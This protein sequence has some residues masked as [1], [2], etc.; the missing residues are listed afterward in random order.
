MRAIIARASGIVAA[1]LV[2]LLASTTVWASNSYVS[3]ITYTTN[4]FHPAPGEPFTITATFFGA[5][6]GQPCHVS[7]IKASVQSQV[8]SGAPS[9]GTTHP[10][11][12]LTTSFRFSGVSSGSLAPSFSFDTLTANGK[13]TCNGGSVSVSPGG[14]TAPPSVQP[15]P[16]PALGI[17]KTLTSGSSSVVPGE[18]ATYRI[19][20]SN[21]GNGDASGLTITDTLSSHLLFVSAPVSAPDTVVTPAVGNSGVVTW[22][23]GSLAAGRTKDF[24]LSVKI[25]DDGF[26]GSVSNQANVKTATE[27]KNSNT[28]TLDVK[29]VPDIRLHKTINGNLET[30]VRLPAG[31]IVEYQIRYENVG[32]G[33]A[34][35]VV[36]TDRIPDELIGTPVL[37]GGTA[38]GWSAG[39]R[40]ATWTIDSVPAGAS[41]VVRISAQINPALTVTDFDN[42]ASVI[43]TGG[44]STDSNLVNVQVDPEPNFEIQ[45]RVDQLH[46]KPGEQVNV[47]IALRNSGSVKAQAVSVVDYL[48][49]G[50]TPVTGTY[51]TGVYD[52]AAVPRK[53]LTWSLGDI[54]PGMPA[55]LSYTVT[56]D[57]DAPPGDATNIAIVSATNL[58]IPLQA[59]AKT[60]FAVDGVVDLVAHKELL[61]PDQDHVADGDDV[62]YK[63]W[64]ENKGNRATEGGITLTDNL[65]PG[66]VY[67][68]TGQNWNQDSATQLSQVIS[69]I[70]AGGRS[71]DYLLTLGVDGS[72]V[73]DGAILDNQVAVKNTT[74]GVEYRHI[75]DP[76]RVYYNLPPKITLTKTAKPLPTQPVFPGDVIDYTLT[77]KLE[78]LAGVDDLVVGDVLPPGLTFEG[79]V[80]AGYSI[81]TATDGRQIVSWP[82]TALHAGERQYHLRARVDA[83]LP[84]GT[85][86]ENK[87]A[88]SYNNTLALA[89]V[90][91]HVTEAAI[92]LEKTR[93]DLQAQ[94]IPG[95]VLRYDLT[96][97]NTGKIPLTDIVLT[98]NLPLD[99][100]LEFVKPAP[101]TVENGGRTLIWNLPPLD[102]GR[103]NTIQVNINT[104]NV[105]VGDQLT[106]TA[107]IKSKET[108]QQSAS[109]VSDVREAPRLVITKSADRSTAYPGDTVTFTLHYANKGKGSAEDV[110]LI[111]QLPSELTFLS[112]TDQVAPDSNGLINWN[113]GVLKP[114]ASGTKLIKMTVPAAGQYV[115]A[116]GIDN[117]VALVSQKDADVDFATV[118]LTE[119]PS[120]TI[121]KR[122]GMLAPQAIGTASPGDALHYV[123]DL[124]KTGGAATDVLVADLLP[125]HTTYV[126]NSA[127][128]PLDLTLSNIDAGLLVWNVGSLPEGDSAGQLDF[129]AV[130]DSV[131]DNGTQLV[132]RA[133]LSST[134][135]GSQ[136]SNEVVTQIFSQPVFGLVKK[137][138]KSS[139]FSPATVSGGTGDTVVYYL[140]VTNSGNTDATNV[141]ISD[142]LPKE[143]VIDP[144]STTG[145]V[146]D[147]SVTWT[148]PTLK[149]G[150]PITLSVAATVQVGV[151]EGRTLA[152]KASLTTTM[153]GVGG[154]SSNEVVVTVSGE[155]IMSMTKSASTKSVVP[156]ERFSYT[157]TYTNSGTKISDALRIEDD[158]PSYVSFVSASR[159]GAPDSQQP[160]TVVWNNLAP[161]APGAS[162]SVE[163]LV[164]V[165]DI[166]PN[167]TPLAN[168]ALLAPVTDPGNSTPSITKGKPPTVSSGPLLEMA[169]VSLTGDTVVAGDLVVFDLA[170]VNLGGDEAT[171]L[172][173]TDTLPPGM[174]FVDASGNY[175]LQR[176]TITWTAPTLPAKQ[177]ANVTLTV[178][179]DTDLDNGY[180]LINR[181]SLTANELPLPLIDTAEVVVRN[182]VLSISKSADA[183]VVNSGVS[184]T[185]QPGDTLIYQLDYANLGDSD[186]SDVSIVETLPPEVT[187]INAVPEPDAIDGQKLTWNVASLPL[188]ATTP[189]IVQTQVVD[190]LREGTIIHNTA[191]ISSPATG[192]QLSNEVDTLVFSQ[193][194][195]AIEKSSAQVSVEAGETIAYDISVRNDGSDSIANIEVVDTLPANA[196]FLNA[197]ANG[198]HSGEAVGG[199]VTWSLPNPLLPGEVAVLHLKATV[200][201]DQ[202]DGDTVFN[203]VSAF[204]ETPSGAALPTVTDTLTTPVIGQPSLELVYSVNR[205]VVV[206]DLG[207]RYT[208]RFR[209]SGNADALNPVLSAT[210]PPNTRPES[211]DAGGR[212]ENGKAVWSTSS[213]PPTGVIELEFTVLVQQ[214]A[215][216]GDLLVSKAT[217]SADNAAPRGDQARTRVIGQPDLEV[218]K[219]GPRFFTPGDT[220]D[221]T[222]TTSNIGTAPAPGV[223]LV[224]Q[225][226]AGTTF[227]SSTPAP[228]SQAG[229]S[230]SWDLGNVLNGTLIPV[231]L[232]VATDSNLSTPRL[233][234]LA[235]VSDLQRDSDVSQWESR[236]TPITTLDIVITPDKLIERP[237]EEVTFTVHWQNTGNQD[238]SGTVV[239][240]TLPS[241]TTLTSE[242]GGT[243]VNGAIE[244]LVGDL[245]AGEQGEKTFVA[246]VSPTA[247][248]GTHV[249]SVAS[250][251][252]NTGAPASSSA[253]VDVVVDPVVW[254]A[255]SAS[256]ATAELGDTVTF[257]IDYQNTG[258]AP[259]TEV[260]LVD[261]LPLGLE[262]V[263]ASDGGVISADGATVTWAL[264]DVPASTSR[265]VTVEVMVTAIT[266]DEVTNTATLA[267]RELPDQS[268]TATL[269]LVQSATPVPIGRDWLLLLLAL[270][271]ALM[272]SATFRRAGQA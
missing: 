75:S 181:A 195:L 206:P 129:Y 211:I 36:I 149:V 236:F 158:L 140:M 178:K 182:A 227:V 80:D 128:I 262:A 58:P 48:P 63:I 229:Q 239:R 156:G 40:E 64:V 141:T 70:A 130:I 167:K 171:G 110:R 20:V 86:L 99:T 148:I 246:R 223:T 196:A 202:F 270:L 127:N 88:A 170:V 142:H 164:Q 234:N 43:W 209:N 145:T 255:K 187:F 54:D 103:S 42:Q 132:N 153:P 108:L 23:V 78:T 44:A 219:V 94:I 85:P 210:L 62:T 247:T 237:S 137:A 264:A 146:V 38:R 226:P 49:D 136:L 154:I 69:D 5:G 14:G 213:L 124:T 79:S 101:T 261:N 225:L 190:D 92:T 18:V 220:I 150:V 257:S 157:L 249:V 74:G 244:W 230:L 240:A 21:K 84:L 201:A 120:F 199:S 119:L 113:L 147:Q 260:V 93:S 263:S 256:T 194:V 254:L 8:V 205:A 144:T 10:N 180:S 77:A 185:G 192:T 212:F 87:G 53:T 242:G 11:R 52:P 133:G 6:N 165:N 155:P 174:T 248:A 163:V 105:Q 30:G 231:T 265:S 104:D 143:L 271:T 207:I 24:N 50:V 97:T 204:G 29:R 15:T 45:K 189:I 179:T 2:L 183:S 135:T 224:D 123:I 272:A 95:E 111:D 33:E 67:Q 250:I 116:V 251:T 57:A 191:S 222:I 3:S 51:G 16:K 61:K 112:A 122:E 269:S 152:N 169:K 238:T 215:Q 60:S 138:S 266:V 200:A 131:V 46:A 176:D 25:A 100:S 168:T 173:L 34:K 233:D 81:T 107:F 72:V 89:S 82:A 102:P 221:Y 35:D 186:A 91:H 59:S 216:V 193:G 71:G 162:D 203:R 243:V 28:V 65:L 66:L 159:G 114:G 47:T 184:A 27:D 4:P 55:I 41:Q 106:N 235:Q 83:G 258:G 161:V 172:T 39:S 197:T 259:L 96:Y 245:G 17:T 268:A 56:V 121:E 177:L 19:S 32:F 37:E 232:T 12:S 175:T 241:F 76:A 109:V 117:L 98:D 228:T 208:L 134:E 68:A 214:G 22:T 139:V 253:S 9:S 13:T 267:S 7:Q 73:P 198:V 217:F 252:A 31:S 218:T 115:P 26:A 90:T 166:V 188:Y 151:G 160:G 1:T 125:E 126:P 118:T